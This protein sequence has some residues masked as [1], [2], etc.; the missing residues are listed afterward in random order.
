MRNKGFA[1]ILF[2]FLLINVVISGGRFQYILFFLYAST[3]GLSYLFLVINEKFLYMYFNYITRSSHTILGTRKTTVGQDVEVEYNLSNFGFLPI[4]HSVV[5]IHL[6]RKLMGFTEKSEKILFR[7]YQVIR[8]LKKIR[9]ESRGIYDLVKVEVELMDPLGLFRKVKYFDFGINLVAYPRIFPLEGISDDF[10]GEQGRLGSRKRFREDYSNLKSLREYR[11]GDSARNI[12]WK[13]STIKNKLMT[14]EYEDTRSKRVSILL[15]GFRGDFEG[16]M[17]YELDEKT[18]EIAGSL[19]NYF[20]HRGMGMDLLMWNK[21]KKTSLSGSGY[22][23]LRDFM[24]ISVVYEP[25][26]QVSFADRL[27]SELPHIGADSVVILV[28]PK[29]NEE[30][31]KY[32][33]EEYTRTHAV[34]IITCMTDEETVER[35]SRFGIEVKV[36]GVSEKIGGIRWTG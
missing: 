19:V 32:L 23:M 6:S 21:G 12:H 10:V 33:R 27:R 17:K 1:T 7:P 36:I 30:L 13:T 22:R 28:T 18:V 35:L 14:R 15:N 8:L 16:M 24:E 20:A 25:D 2:I 34:K 4:M 3:I 31:Y 9:V 26:S 5:T 11:P 29:I